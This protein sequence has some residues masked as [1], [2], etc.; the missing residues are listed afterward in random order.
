MAE[1]GRFA[2]RIET[3]VEEVMAREYEFE[4][5]GDSNWELQGSRSLKGIFQNRKTSRQPHRESCF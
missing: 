4:V 2:E 5:I 3:I 1:C